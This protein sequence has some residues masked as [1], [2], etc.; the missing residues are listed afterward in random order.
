MIYTCEHQPCKFMLNAAQVR[1]CLMI[2]NKGFNHV[3]LHWG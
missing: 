3:N 1:I 2:Y